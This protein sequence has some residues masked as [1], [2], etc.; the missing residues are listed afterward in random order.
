MATAAAAAGRRELWDGRDCAHLGNFG[1]EEAA[2]RAYDRAC[3]AQHGAD[4]NTNYP[5]SVRPPFPLLPCS[6]PASL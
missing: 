1:T 6:D 4:A 5:P 3:L 2:T